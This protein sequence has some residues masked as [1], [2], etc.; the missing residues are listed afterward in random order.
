[1]KTCNLKSNLCYQ[2]HNRSQSFSYVQAT[3]YPGS[4]SA[5]RMDLNLQDNVWEFSKY[6]LNAIFKKKM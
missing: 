6:V 2:L 1:M 3:G 4:M 5:V